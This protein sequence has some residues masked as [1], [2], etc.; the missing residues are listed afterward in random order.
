MTNKSVVKHS[1][2]SDV[3]VNVHVDTKPIAYAMLCTLLASKQISNE[4]FEEAV[5]R[6]DKLTNREKR[7]MKNVDDFIRPKLNKR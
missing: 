7:K 4:E 3:D 6:L 2:N 1:G 5:S